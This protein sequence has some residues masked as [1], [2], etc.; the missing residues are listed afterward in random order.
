M[1]P[2]ARSESRINTVIHRGIQPVAALFS[3]AWRRMRGL[4]I[5]TAA[6]VPPEMARLAAVDRVIQSSAFRQ[7]Q[8]LRRLL[9]YLADKAL[10]GTA[11]QLKE[12]TIGVDALGKPSSYDPRQDS[13]VRIH[14]G[15]LRQ[16]LNEYYRTEG[17][18]DAVVLDLPKGHFKLQFE[19]RQSPAPEPATPPAT[20]APAKEAG[21]P[22]EPGFRQRSF[23]FLIA[24]LI[25]TT[26]SAVWSA[27]HLLTAERTS[28]ISGNEWNREMQD[29]W[30]PFV[31]PGSPVII[32]AAYP[33]FIDLDGAG[34]YR[35]PAAES[36]EQAG[37]SPRLMA[38]RKALG[39]PAILARHGYT[40]AGEAN[41]LFSLGRIFT[42]R[43]QSVSITRSDQLTWQQLADNNV[44]MIGNPRYFAPLL[45]GLPSELNY[46]LEEDGVRVL[47]PKSGEPPRMPDRYAVTQDS[48]EVYALITHVPGPLGRGDI[49]SFCSNHDSG[50]LAAVHWFTNPDLVRTLDGKTQT[51]NGGPPR[52]YQVVL[53][54]Q[55]HETVPIA[56]SLIAHSQV[57]V[58]P[59][60]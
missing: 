24:A 51:T 38:I 6:M 37:T 15:R 48:G 23:P 56:V 12:Y 9:R 53:K 16:R 14:V 42:G 34:L 39:N 50:T 13:A 57:G 28:A 3:R 10:E 41:A 58:S 26:A 27:S 20:N 2:A 44:I 21:R 46:V 40:T 31:T 22:A 49:L 1:Q 59:A 52:F 54:V 47:H 8:T 45:K 17:S 29:L 43:N 11:D 35:D 25:L 60:R 4:Y 18:D 32:S 36:L 7:S 33:L 5:L 55:Y 30:K 19:N